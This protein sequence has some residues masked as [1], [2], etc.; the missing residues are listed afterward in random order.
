MIGS[1]STVSAAANIGG[2]SSL[3]IYL[4]DGDLVA[5]GT[6]DLFDGTLTTG[7]GLSDDGIYGR[8]VVWTGTRTDGS[9]FIPLAL[10]FGTPFYGLSDLRDFNWVAYSI[11]DAA[12]PFSLY[13]ISNT[14][15]VPGGVP[16]PGTAGLAL[17]GFILIAALMRK[18]S[19]CVAQK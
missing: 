5:N 17:T 19:I 3:P 4:L 8:R 1:T 10:G 9:S 7:I 6:A 13:G 15:T 16:E 11:Y 12:T 14:L 2:V 18:S